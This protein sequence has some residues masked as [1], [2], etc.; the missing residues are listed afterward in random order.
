M[1]FSRSQEVLT[2]RQNLEQKKASK[3]LGVWI[4]EDTGSWNQNTTDLCKSAYGRMSMLTKLR[5]V[6]VTRADLVDVYMMCIHSMAEYASVCFHSS[7]SQE[8]TRKIENIQKTRVKIIYQ[9]EH[10][11]YKLA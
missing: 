6:G 3:L 1:V 5:Y 7:L 9:E 4:E 2:T 11:D 10:T 8:Q